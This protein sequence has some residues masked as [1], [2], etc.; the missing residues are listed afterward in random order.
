MTDLD[1]LGHVN[2]GV[3]YSYYDIGRFDYLSQINEDIHWETLDK[4]I[5]RTECDFMKSIHYTDD[6][7][8]ETK[9]IEIGKKSVKMMQRIIDNNS[10]EI[11]STCLS[12]LS[13]Y[14]RQNNVSKEISEE[15]KEKV[16]A[17]ENGVVIERRLVSTAEPCRNAAL[18]EGN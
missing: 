10:G 17:F 13:G 2:N 6:I 4:V 15:F 7:S 9:V 5:V 16:T 1:P 18:A 11:K 3:F 8:V 14:D 12:V